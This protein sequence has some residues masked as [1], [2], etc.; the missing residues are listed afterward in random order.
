MVKHV[1]EWQNVVQ[2]IAALRS[3][4]RRASAERP[5]LPVT[6][7]YRGAPTLRVTESGTAVCVVC[8][9]C[10][11]TCPTQCIRPSR[12]DD[13]VA[14]NLERERCMYCGLCARVCPVDAIELASATVDRHKEIQ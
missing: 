4:L 14:L 5:L 9:R 13:E 11:E 8:D 12:T 6:L 3:T 2:A 10:A 7:A 1:R